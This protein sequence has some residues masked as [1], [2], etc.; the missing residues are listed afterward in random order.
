VFVFKRQSLCVTLKRSKS[1]KKIVFDG[2]CSENYFI[3][4]LFMIK[5][6]SGELIVNIVNFGCA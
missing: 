3:D 1:K 2:S 4:R 6:Q 5:N